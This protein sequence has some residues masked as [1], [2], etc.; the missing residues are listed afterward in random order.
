M[1]RRYDCA[2]FLLT[3]KW[4]IGVAKYMAS[5]DIHPVHFATSFHHLFFLPCCFWALYQFGRG[6]PRDSYVMSVVLTSALAVAARFLTP[7]AVKTK[8]GQ[9]VFNI[10]LSYAFWAD[11]KLP[12]VHAFDFCAPY[13][14]LPYLII[15]CN[16]FLNTLP[17][18]LLYAVANRYCVL[19]PESTFVG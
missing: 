11:I 3:R 4:P 2:G 9:K 5:P 16:L 13:L 17:V 19:F 10:N 8:K 18:V 6:M 12:F 14:Y 7:Y 1:S 15:V